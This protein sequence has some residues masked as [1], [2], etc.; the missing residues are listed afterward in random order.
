MPKTTMPGDGGSCSNK[1][2]GHRGRGGE[3]VERPGA[4]APG[5]H[6]PGIE[7]LH[8]E[9]KRVK[10]DRTIII[11]CKLTNGYEILNYI[12]ST[13]ISLRKKKVLVEQIGLML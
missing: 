6:A 1:R 8:R 2:A 4:I 7:I 13:K 11:N 5:D 12:K 9:A 10:F 3:G